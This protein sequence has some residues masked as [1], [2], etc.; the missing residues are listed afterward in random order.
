[1]LRGATRGCADVEVVVGWGA[2]GVG[3]GEEVV[4]RGHARA[5]T[6]GCAGSLILRGGGHDDGVPRVAWAL[7][8]AFSAAE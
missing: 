2:C 4:G 7:A 1:M 6:R 5:A 3:M 8:D